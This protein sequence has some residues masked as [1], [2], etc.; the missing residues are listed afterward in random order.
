M[1]VSLPCCFEY[2]LKHLSVQSETLSSTPGKSTGAVYMTE[3]RGMGNLLGSDVSCTDI[4]FFHHLWA[5][6]VK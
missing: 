2:V 4:A 1:I 3:R 5:S 6:N